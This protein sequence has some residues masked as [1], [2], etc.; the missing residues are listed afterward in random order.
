MAFRLPN[1]SDLSFEQTDII[2]LPITKN[3]V[4][5]GD[6]GTG[7]T[8][9]AI[10]RAAQVARAYP[11]D[12]VLV[13]VY[14]KPLMLFLQSA[15]NGLG[16]SNIEIATYHSWLP[17]YYRSVVGSTIPS[18]A[19]YVYDWQKVKNDLYSSDKKYKHIIVDEAQDFPIEL[20]EIIKLSAEH[21]TC[22]IDPNQKI[23]ENNTGVM[24]AIKTL[25]VE[26]PY[27]LTKNFRNTKQIR[28]FS[29]LY[30]IDGEPAKAFVSGSKPHYIQAPRMNFNAQTDIVCRIVNQN[31]GKNIGIIVN[32][33][34]LN[35]T[36]NNVKA[37]V[38]NPDDVQMY[39]SMKNNDIDFNTN[40]VKIVSYGTMKG[41]EFDIVILPSFDKINSTDDD[42]VDKNRIYVATSRPIN[43]LYMIKID[44]KIGPRYI[45]T[46]SVVDANS[47]LVQP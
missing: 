23:D 29:A 43:E 47:D 32:N 27:K 39:K 4:I 44:T 5:K 25:C 14:N 46:T 35:V 6:P 34:S 18:V 9:M 26:S 11:N 38:K 13:V 24:Q 37:G 15:V 40:G 33:K 22:F 31:R 1:G 16:Y 17:N 3:W 36:Y 20:L 8:V 10:Y 30:C 21:I 45:D 12:K 28:D 41:L 42:V 2:N 19:P 7:K